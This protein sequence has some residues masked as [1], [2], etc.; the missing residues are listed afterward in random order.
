MAA[1]RSM[2]ALAMLAPMLF[3]AAPLP[4]AAQDSAVIT[5]GPDW[6][7][8]QDDR[9]RLTL[10]SITFDS[11]VGIAARCRRGAFE[12]ILAGL[13]QE[14]GE[15]FFRTLGVAFRDG[16][17]RDTSW[18]VSE[19][20]TGAFNH[21]PARFARRLRE[22]GQLQIRV[23]G[24]RGAASVRYVLDLP[25]SATAVETV[26]TACGRPLEDRRDALLPDMVREG[27]ESVGLQWVQ[28][29]RGEYPLSANLKWAS[30]ALTCIVQA[31]GRLDDCIVESEHPGGY[32]F[33]EAAIRA[34]RRG[35]VGATP[36]SPPDAMI[37]GRQITYN[38]T[39]RLED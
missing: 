36:D 23:P 39:F 2:K 14:P 31:D 9:R 1:S 33:G 29:P 27:V 37:A 10:A 8:V 5:P 35:R 4:A 38:M 18:T 24:Q 12:V 17:F 26:L 3:F 13:P 6:D 16:E 19:D 21:L 11:G 32:K 25:P 22:G 20:R 28:R 15:G 7:L 30:V 34:A